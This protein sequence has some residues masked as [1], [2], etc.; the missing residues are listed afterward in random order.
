MEYKDTHFIGAFRYVT[1]C[2]LYILRNLGVSASASAIFKN[3]SRIVMSA[4][5]RALWINNAEAKIT[6]AYTQ[7]ASIVILF[8][9]IRG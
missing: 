1:T 8:I 5:S 9:L 2:T 3:L 6:T 4:I 7:N